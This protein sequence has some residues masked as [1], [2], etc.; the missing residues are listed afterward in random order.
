MEPSSTEFLY[1]Y[2]K[3]DESFA[4]SQRTKAAIADRSDR[5]VQCLDA[6]LSDTAFI[7]PPKSPDVNIINLKNLGRGYKFPP[8]EINRLMSMVELIN[9]RDTCETCIGELQ[10]AESSGIMLD[11]DIY[12]KP[13]KNGTMLRPRDVMKTDDYIS[14]LEIIGGTILNLCEIPE[15]LKTTY[16]AITEKPDLVYKEEKKADKFGFH[17]LIPGLKC[18]RVFKRLLIEEL[19]KDPEYKKCFKHIKVPDGKEFESHE[20]LDKN[21]AHVPVFLVGST[22]KPGTPAY[23]VSHIFEMKFRKG[24]CNVTDITRSDLFTIAKQTIMCHEFSLNFESVKGVI[25]K[26]DLILLPTTLKTLTDRET[27]KDSSE[28]V[29]FGSPL[30]LLYISD[31]EAKYIGKM[32]DILNDRRADDYGDWMKVLFILSKQ[33]KLYKPLA[34]QFSRRSKKFDL[35]NFNTTWDRLVSK[36]QQ[37]GLTIGTLHFWAK[38]DNKERY[39]QLKNGHIG[40]LVYNAAYDTATGGEL[41]HTHISEFISNLIGYKFMYEHPPTFQHGLWYEFILDTDEQIPGEIWKWRVYEGGAHPPRLSK[42]ISTQLTGVFR[43]V[44]KRIAQQMKDAKDKQLEKYH[45]KIF[46]NLQRTSSRIGNNNTI[47]GIIGRCRDEFSKR[48]IYDNM[49]K[50]PDIMGVSNGVLIV[51]PEVVAG[52]PATDYKFITGY[53]S[54]YLTMYSQ[55]PYVPFN[56]RNPYVKTMLYTLKAIFPDEESDAWLFVMLFVASALNGRMKDN[57]ILIL[58]GD[59]RAGKSVIA[60]YSLKVFGQYAVKMKATYLSSIET[61]PNAPDP[62]LLMLKTARL[63]TYSELDRETTVNESKVKEMLGQ[64]TLNARPPFAKKPEQFLANAS[65]LLATNHKFNVQGSDDAIWARLVTYLCKIR[66]CFDHE[67]PAEPS[68]FFKKRNNELNSSWLRNEDSE[69]PTAFFSILTWFYVTYR[70]RLKYSLHYFNAPT[71]QSETLKYRASQDHVY[72]YIS[73]HV[74]QSVNYDKANPSKTYRIPFDDFIAQYPIWYKKKTGSDAKIKDWDAVIRNS[75]LKKHIVEK[76]RTCYIEGYRLLKANDDAEK[77][78]F[79]P[80]KPIVVDSKA[81]IFKESADEMYDRI[82]KEYDSGIPGGLLPEALFSRDLQNKTPGSAKPKPESKIESK[83]ESK[84]GPSPVSTEPELKKEEPKPKL[85][86]P[87]KE[88]PKV[89]SEKVKSEKEKEKEKEKEMTKSKKKVSKDE[90]F[91]DDD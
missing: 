3:D 54:Y 58:K 21:S 38:Q 30:S 73:S 81:P 18:S 79:F 5:V 60:E 35:D 57:F 11:H 17:I 40:S 39:D 23:K 1:E 59:G 25:K 53:H 65:H 77:D 33:S 67:M 78:E 50:N 34:E 47:L 31:P 6:L 19:T 27:K 24:R 46:N 13:S 91:S 10:N 9:L 7:R 14:I 2:L 56:P 85:E 75:I 74:V 4:L 88:E 43:E 71:V 37:T 15:E 20:I 66:F 49:N 55:V 62:L 22:K 69:Y 32:L 80:F 36:P 86:E 51:N 61:N 76:R 12:I 16:A 68:P 63:A 89:K 8:K 52:S 84:T 41:N 28:T 72:R 44:L 26:E 42:Y 45:Q 82:C 70:D 83:I 87:K 29:E 48:G 90:V 64:E